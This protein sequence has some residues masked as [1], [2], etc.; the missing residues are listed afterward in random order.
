MGRIMLCKVFGAC[1]V[2]LG[3]GGI[4]IYMAVR[5]H[6]RIRIIRELEQVLQYL[7]GEI[8]YAAP[9]MAEL[10]ERLSVRKGFFS[11]FFERMR[12]RILSHQGLRFQ[13]YWKEEMKNIKE[14]E[15]LSSSDRELLIQIGENLGNLDR[16]TQL[17]TL[18]LFEKRLS[19]IRS[20]AEK[21]YYGKARI[22]IVVWA[23]GGIFLVLLFL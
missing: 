23:T 5:S 13:D 15:T 16:M 18:E 10:M 11:Y 22:S 3:C 8:E 17:R 4:G 7:Y 1:L 6:V 2:F 12:E 14:M 20:K 19:E 21:E 9:D